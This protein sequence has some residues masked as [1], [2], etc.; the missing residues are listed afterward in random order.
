MTPDER[1]PHIRHISM[2]IE[3]AEGLV[4]RKYPSSYD[5]TNRGERALWDVPST[6]QLDPQKVCV[7][8]CTVAH[9]CIVPSMD[10]KTLSKVLEGI[11]GPRSS[12]GMDGKAA[13]RMT[14][15]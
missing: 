4:G 1:R 7:Y 6:S 8:Y 12:G 5:E 15:L 2:K 10:A 11:L 13:D 3:I 9:A 14:C